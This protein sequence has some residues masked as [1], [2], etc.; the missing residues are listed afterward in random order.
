MAKYLKVS[1]KTLQRWRDRSVKKHYKP[2]F[3]AAVKEATA[4]VDT[5]RIKRSMIDRA[6][7][8]VRVKR[9]VTVAETE[10]GEFTTTRTERE[11]MLGDVAAAKL[12]LAN[13]GPKE[14]RWIEKQAHVMTQEPMTPAECDNV[15][16]ILRQ[17]QETAE[18]TRKRRAAAYKERAI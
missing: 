14:E 16:E 11:K 4:A 5:E 6:K 10:D 15:R 12:C 2:E 1:T 18:E 13:L 9:T 3:A 17:N 8:Y 7:G